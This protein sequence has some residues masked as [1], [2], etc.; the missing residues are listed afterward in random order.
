MWYVIMYSIHIL[1][2]SQKL[3]FKSSK[4]GFIMSTSIVILESLYCK[5]SAFKSLFSLS[6]MLFSEL[7]YDNSLEQ[8][9]IC[10]KLQI[11][12]IR[13]SLNELKMYTCRA[14]K[15]IWR[16]ARA[17]ARVSWGSGGAWVVTKKS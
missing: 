4:M 6:L 3:L 12:E 9:Q 14:D 8:C 1:R 15:D 10:M 7:K 2:L 17:R 5:Q 16:R 13:K 11:W